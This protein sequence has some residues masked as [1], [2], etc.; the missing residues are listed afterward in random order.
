MHDET[1][2]A[3]EPW[4]SPSEALNRFHPPEGALMGGPSAAAAQ[5]VRFGFCVG[6]LR[7]LIEPSTLSEVIRRPSI[8]PMPNVSAWFT[9]V[10]NLR[11][12][13][14][15]VFDLHA[16][17]GMGDCDRSPQTVLILDSGMDSIGLRIDGLPQS[18]A[19]D[20]GLRQAPPLPEALEAHVP[21]AYATEGAIWL[22]FDHQRFLTTL[23]QRLAS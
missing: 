3:P 10:M 20:R 4:L 14:L 5:S 13:V 11:G 6:Q 15:P 7:L 22:E 18:V 21:R 17:F 19:L 16:L 2:G 9:G 12:N 1:A 23:G 8:Y